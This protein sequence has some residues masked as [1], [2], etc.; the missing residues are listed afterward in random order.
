MTESSKPSPTSLSI[1]NKAIGDVKRAINE[2]AKTDKEHAEMTD[3][4]RA[5]CKHREVVR[6][7]TVRFLD[8]VEGL[9]TCFCDKLTEGSDRLDPSG[10][11][12]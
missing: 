5:S 9:M 12:K 4:E 11:H 2:A 8:H 7:N 6:D 1:V 3:G 10:F